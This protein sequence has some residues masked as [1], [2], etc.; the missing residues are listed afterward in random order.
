LI[1]LFY[2]LETGFRHL[3]T[4]D[5][6]SP[7]NK[8]TLVG[9]ST[10]GKFFFGGLTA[11]TFG[12]GCWQ[13][14]RYSEKMEQIQQRQ[15]ELQMPPSSDFK[16]KEYPY[17]RKQLTGTFIYDKEVLVGPRGAPFDPK[18]A[19]AGGMGPSPQ[20]FM[21]LTPLQ[22]VTGQLVWIN[23]GWVPKAMVPGADPRGGRPSQM[24][25][26]HEVN[27]WDRPRGVVDVT[28][29]R[30]RPER[31]SIGSRRLRRVCVWK[32][33]NDDDFLG[34]DMLDFLCISISI[35]SLDLGTLLC[36]LFLHCH[37]TQNDCD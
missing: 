3:S 35:H 26:P 18:A 23:R 1:L 28:A 27:H 21:V 5:F 17:Q 36:I 30:S 11:G 22:L 37:R 24:I 32:N 13:V 8:M 6:S 14:I 16:T 33:T 19:G 4:S 12:L 15:Q 34:R 20:G 25:S 2:S 9:L 29:I 10:G 7:N 31:K